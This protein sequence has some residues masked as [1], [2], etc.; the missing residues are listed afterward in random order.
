MSL[1][2][3]FTSV[4]ESR[5]S[6]RESAEFRNVEKAATLR[7]S[8]RSRAFAR[9]IPSA[10]SFFNPFA[11][12]SAFL[13]GL[14]RA[15]ARSPLASQR[16]RIILRVAVAALEASK[17]ALASWPRSAVVS[18]IENPKEFATGPTVESEDSNLEKSSAVLVVATAKVARTSSV[19]LASLLNIRRAAPANA[20]ALERSVSTA[21]AN[22]NTAPSIFRIWSCPNPSLANSI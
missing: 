16:F 5:N 2:C 21:F 1:N 13:T 11:R 12:S 14:P 18:S 22:F 20:E 8:V 7:L 4:I 15:F 3:L 6:V 9:S 10:L 19:S 17:P